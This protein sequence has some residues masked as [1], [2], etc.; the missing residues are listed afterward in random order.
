MVITRYI[1]HVMW[2][3]TY[4]LERHVY[5]TYMYANVARIPGTT[6][7]CATS[8]WNVKKCGFIKA[9]GHFTKI[10]LFKI[11]LPFSLSQ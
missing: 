7:K 11:K 5:Y 4:T 2:D 8:Q 10:A 1:Y 3:C 9:I 6:M